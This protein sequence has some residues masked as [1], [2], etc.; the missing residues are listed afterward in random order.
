[1]DTR[2]FALSASL[3][4]SLLS[5]SAS[6]H[7]QCPLVAPEDPV[8]V[9]LTHEAHK[10]RTWRYVWTGLNEGSMVISIAA[11]PVLSEAER[12]DLI[13]GAATAGLSGAV[14]WFWPLD[15]ESDAEGVESTW[16]LGPHER[17][18]ELLRLRQHSA[19]DEASRVRW[20]WHV[21]NLVTALIPGAILWFGFHDRL[22]S[23]ISTA[24]SFASGELE[25]IT[26]PTYLANHHPAE[27]VGAVRPTLIQH[28]ALL[29]YR[30][31][32]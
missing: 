19:D 6:V 18:I 16:C 15:V 4:A 2:V 25:L 24:T 9:E 12:P 32:W 10:A 30:T 5:A 13:M 31:S 3:M 26:Q 1:M 8:A 29:T 14:S 22:D 20:P 23:V 7:A 11:I 28:G 21:G 27:G 17:H